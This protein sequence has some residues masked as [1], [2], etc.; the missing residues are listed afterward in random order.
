VVIDDLDVVCIS[1][2]PAETDPPLGVDPNA[3]LAGPIPLQL[4]QTIARRQPQIIE[5]RRCIEHTELPERDPLEICPQLSH[6]EA[7]EETFGIAVP[8]ALDHGE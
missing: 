3:M 5:R 1:G 6:R 2:S 7:L 4:L 8:E